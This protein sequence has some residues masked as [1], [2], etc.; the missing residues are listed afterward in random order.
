MNNSFTVNQI[1][2]LKPK[3]KP[4]LV[5]GGKGFAIRVMPSGT[6]TWQFIYTFEGKRKW[7][8]L[9][10]FPEVSLKDANTKY[11][12]ALS[13]LEK[14]IDPGEFNRQKDEDRRKEPYMNDLCAEYLE[15]HAKVKKRLRSWQE[16]ERMINKDIKPRFDKVK[17]KE[18]TK[19][20]IVLMLEDIYDRGAKT[21]SNRMLALVRKIFNF[22]IG[23]DLLQTNPCN[24]IEKLHA[25]VSKD[26]YLSDAEI[27]K[28]WKGLEGSNMTDPVRRVLKMILLTGQRP[29]EVLNVEWSEIN[30]NW[31]TI[32]A[33]KTKNKQEHRV[34]LTETA[35]KLLGARADGFVFKSPRGDKPM[36][37]NT[38]PHA[39]QRNLPLLA[40]VPF[41]PHD[42]RRTCATGITRLGFPRFLAGQVLNHKDKSITGVYDRYEYDQEKQKISQR[43]E[44]KLQKLATG[45][46]NQANVIPFTRT[47]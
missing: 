25:E 12:D 30:G 13:L 39:I 11:K 26:R 2:S 14:D 9:G 1:K 46:K 36:H 10:T 41:T 27:S 19:R 45:D 8:S 6:K 24:G 38:L 23:R 37:L 31:W 7:Y 17:A 20:D 3:D 42:L 44:R 32:P 21:H 22:G 18:I 34:Y 4:Y 33:E 40:D 47:T 28:F 15:K 16:D 43:W 29:G 35:K 5:R